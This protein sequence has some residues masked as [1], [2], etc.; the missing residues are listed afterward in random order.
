MMRV[1]QVVGSMSPSWGG[2]TRA[3]AGLTEAM[4]RRGLEVK[5]V[6]TSRGRETQLHP[7]GV[8]VE[9][10]PTTIGSWRHARGLRHLLIQSVA[11]ADLVHIHG[12]WLYP[13]FLASRIAQKARKPYLVSP[14]GMLD[15]WALNQRRL[16]KRVY[17]AIIERNTLCKA[18]LIHAVSDMEVAAV[19]RLGLGV[20]VLLVP[21]GIDHREFAQAFD[22][23]SVATRF[24]QLAGK[25][26][27]LFMGRVHPKKGLDLLAS[28]FGALAKSR[29]DLFLLIVGP[30][31][32]DYAKRIQS[33]LEGGKD[34]CL[35][36]GMFQGEQRLHALALADIFVLPSY[37]EG[38]PLAPL[39]AMAAGLPVILSEQC[40]IPNI[41][42][43]GAGI[44]TAH[45]AESLS[46]AILT[47]VDKPLLRKQMGRNGREL[48]L[49]TYTWENAAAR[50][51][52]SY[53]RCCSGTEV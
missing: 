33:R 47:L 50:L 25:T 31:N 29:P 1:L 19:S 2:L 12:L 16:R 48:V 46:R 27:I 17:N 4:V 36:T 5:I 22:Q 34:Q 43:S 53:D 14:H 23:A 20:P 11:W 9:S 28:T 32:G 3:V 8:K 6:T 39:E 35:F 44:I 30:E 45:N 15:P 21:N 37:S 7:Q 26:V 13:H 49:R 40:N 18:A 42:E 41:E 10:L 51:K 38:F 24:P 52:T